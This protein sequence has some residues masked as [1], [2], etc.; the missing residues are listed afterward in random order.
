MWTKRF[1]VAHSWRRLVILPVVGVLAVA[2]LGASAAADPSRHPRQ[3]KPTVV[4]VHGAWADSSSWDGV[5][6]R[7]LDD[8]YPVDVFPTPLRSL[9]GDSAYLRSYLAAITGPIVLVGHSYGGAVISNAAT[10]NANVKALVYIDAFAP[11]AGENVLQ[12]AGADSALANPDVTKVFNFVPGLPPTPTTDLYVLPGLFPSAFANDLP[13]KQAAVLAV[14]QRPITFGALNEVS[15][16]PAWQSI[17]SWYEV[18]TIDRAIPAAQQLMMAQRAG[19]HIVKVR[20]SHLPMISQP[21]AVE[22]TIEA[23]ARSIH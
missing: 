8:G 6:S 4:L 15:G 9:S 2:A 10:G 21:K 19:A 23:A 22:H 14:T 17:P 1:S 16:A 13:K 3:P 5:V 12:L 18:G 20:S 11:L 7:L